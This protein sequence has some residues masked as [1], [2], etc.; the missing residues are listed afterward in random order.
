MCILLC[1]LKEANFVGGAFEHLSASA[2]IC[3]V[4]ANHHTF[5]TIVMTKNCLNKQL[6][7]ASAERPL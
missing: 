1:A 3:Q 6:L 4:T 2:R 7:L 5:K